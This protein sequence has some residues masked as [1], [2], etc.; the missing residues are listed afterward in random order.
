MTIPDP[1]WKQKT[2]PCPFYSQGRCLFSDSCSFLHDV[3]IRVK[4]PNITITDSTPDVVLSSSLFQPESVAPNPRSDVRSPPRSPRLSSLLLALGDAIESDED[5]QV[6]AVISQAAGANNNPVVPDEGAD[7]EAH[8]AHAI[9]SSL[10]DHALGIAEEVV[11]AAQTIPVD[12][13]IARDSI[14][15]LSPIEVKLAPAFLG[16]LEGPSHREDSI[17]SGYA[18]NWHGPSPFALSPPRQHDSR[19][20]ST[21]SL[22][23]SPF[24]SPAR[25]LSPAFGPSVGS[26]W[27]SS[28]LFSPIRKCLSVSG[29]SLLHD[30]ENHRIYVQE[31]LLQF[32]IVRLP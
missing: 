27:P 30:R 16:Q 17:D 5:E 1:P 10:R 24:G 25:A 7:R 6:D 2:R 15:L 13:A 22:L 14:D 32:V 31:V 8:E 29:T 4:Q 21:L 26:A 28:P 9:S 11:E 18:D 23:S 3:K 12:P 19:R 20:Y